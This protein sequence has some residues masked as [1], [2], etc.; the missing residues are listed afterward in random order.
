MS[1]TTLFWDVMGRASQYTPYRL[2]RWLY[3]RTGGKI[4]GV[5]PGM[6]LRA[7]LLTTTGRKSGV[8]RTH[9]L[10]YYQDGQNFVVA[11][12]NAGADKPPL[13]Y[14][15]LKSHPEAKVQAQDEIHNVVA[16]EASGQEHTCLWGILSELHPMFAAHQR[17]TARQIPVMV[18]QPIQETE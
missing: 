4:G 15:N 5:Y 7:L 8:P 18:L 11:A 6:K 2:H 14:L 9:P 12:S 3:Q 10:M 13:W 1:A 16:H 17:S